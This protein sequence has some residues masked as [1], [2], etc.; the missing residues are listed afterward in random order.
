MSSTSESK[1]VQKVARQGAHV[2]YAVSHEEADPNAK[3]LP[4]HLMPITPEE[5]ANKARV[6]LSRDLGT[7][8]A[9]RTNCAPAFPPVLPVCV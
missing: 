2:A 3:P 9:T 4:P 7:P 8:R 5:A 1:K 6:E